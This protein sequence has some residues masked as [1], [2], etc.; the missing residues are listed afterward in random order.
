MCLAQGLT[1][2]C[3]FGDVC[4]PVGKRLRI[5]GRPN[6]QVAP[7][8]TVGRGTVRRRSFELPKIPP[9]DEKEP[10][11]RGAMNHQVGSDEKRASTFAWPL[12]RPPLEAFCVPSTARYLFSV[13][14]RCTSQSKGKLFWSWTRAESYRVLGGSGGAI[15]N[16]QHASKAWRRRRF[17]LD[18]NA[19]NARTIAPTLCCL[20]VIFRRRLFRMAACPT[21]A[22]SLG[23][24]TSW[25]SP[26][27]RGW[28]SSPL[29]SGCCARSC[30]CF[31]A[32]TW[33]S[34][35]VVCC[36]CCFCRCR[37]R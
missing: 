30:I 37:G 15:S 12:A 34:R 6:M 29:Q 17:E 11:V 25:I 5:F 36:R 24:R 10:Q 16:I 31:P 20:F 27:L 32:T 2:K 33:L 13:N 3:V 21:G 8:T 19:A 4:G 22:V 28:S 18:A 9:P 7:S 26:A 1:Q 23:A 14:E 35:L